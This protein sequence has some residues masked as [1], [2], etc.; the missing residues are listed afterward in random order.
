MIRQA[1]FAEEKWVSPGRFKRLFALYQMLPGSEA[2]QLCV[3]FGMLLRGRL[4]GVL[5]GL[6]GWVRLN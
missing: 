6:I 4:G 3:H 1:L 5:A 2:H